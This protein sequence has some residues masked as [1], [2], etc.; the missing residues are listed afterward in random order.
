[1]FSLS[2]GVKGKTGV[3]IIFPNRFLPALDNE[4][5]VCLYSFGK[6]LGLNGKNGHS[7]RTTRIRVL[8]AKLLTPAIPGSAFR[9][10]AHDPV[11]RNSS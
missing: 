2:K 11:R 3:Q 10:R 8:G 6:I 7:H 5:Y 4:I 9:W 1:M